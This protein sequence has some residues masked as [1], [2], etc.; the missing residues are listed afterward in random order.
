MSAARRILA[1]VLAF[2]LAVAH[3]GSTVIHHISGASS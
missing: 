1:A 3:A 2:V